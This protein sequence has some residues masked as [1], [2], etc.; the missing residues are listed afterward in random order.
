MDSCA[1][2]MKL[3]YFAAAHFQTWIHL[4]SNFA[5]CSGSMLSWLVMGPRN[6]QQAPSLPMYIRVDTVT[7]LFQLLSLEHWV[8]MICHTQMLGTQSRDLDL[9]C[10]Q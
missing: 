9:A 8:Q 10:V 3:D 1:V 4:Q 5:V 2:A 7:K 6:F